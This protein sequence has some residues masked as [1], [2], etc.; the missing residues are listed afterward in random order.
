MTNT[1]RRRET[2]WAYL[3][4]APLLIGLGI[5]YYF[6]LF[7]NL[8]YCFTDLGPFG[9]P[10]LIGWRNYVRLFSDEKFYRALIHTV[11]YV[12]VSV[13]LSLSVPRCWQPC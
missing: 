8:Y 7:Q 1:L 9:K 3:F 5:F 11:K 10:N 6:A 12:V 4:L 13:L 2:L